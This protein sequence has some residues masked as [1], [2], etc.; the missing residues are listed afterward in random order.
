MYGL[1]F[2]P[3]R[4]TSIPA[5]IRCTEALILP[6]RSRYQTS[7]FVATSEFLT[8]S[9]FPTSLE[10]PTESSICICLSGELNGFSSITSTEARARAPRV[11][12][13]WQAPDRE[14]SSTTRLEALILLG[15]SRYQTS[16]FPKEIPAH[17]MRGWDRS[18]THESPLGLE[19]QVLMDWETP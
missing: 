2:R 14:S 17:V 4:C 13:G 3:G 7:N 12:T 16:E 6:G 10:F 5:M 9:E 19:S 8:T 15:R 1:G 11:L 18:S